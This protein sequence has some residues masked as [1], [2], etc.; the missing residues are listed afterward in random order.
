M[1]K[2]AKRARTMLKKM[3]ILG[4]KIEPKVLRRFGLKV[5]EENS[6]MQEKVKREVAPPEEKIDVAPDTNFTPDIVEEMIK[7][8]EELVEEIKPKP[9]RKPRT[10]RVRRPRK[11]K[12]VE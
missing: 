4:E 9:K 8:V 5:P 12:S 2:R 1:G 7:E 11:K 3:S 10:T 6:V